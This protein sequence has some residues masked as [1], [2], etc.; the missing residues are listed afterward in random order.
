MSFPKLVVGN[1]KMHGSSVALMGLAELARSERPACDAAL[2]VPYPLLSTAQSVL[3]ATTLRWGAQDCSA[4]A[5]GAH[6]GEVSAELIARFGARYV[7][8]GHHE[9]RAGHAESDSVVVEKVRRVLAA[10]MTPIVCVGETAGERD[11]NETHSI[12]RQQLLQL[13][14][15]FGRGLS[16]VIIV[17]QP[18]WTIGCG[19]AATPGLIDDTR[20][21]IVHTLGYH[22]GL[23]AGSVRIL[24]GGSVDRRNAGAI[25]SRAGVDGVL[26][27]A[28]SLRP[29]DFIDICR[30]A[31]RSAN[32]GELAPLSG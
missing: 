1:W 22:A 11:D 12:L 10:G 16:A 31:A 17:Y 27:G 24:Y 3:R 21:F 29:D 5:G 25:L 32:E 19:E 18:V 8:V 13:V 7:I 28:A 20:A 6:T 9:R 2:C 26:V 14:R 30:A 23:P 15:H 4:H